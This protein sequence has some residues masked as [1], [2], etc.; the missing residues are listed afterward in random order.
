MKYRFTF[1]YEE[2]L[3]SLRRLPLVNRGIPV[4][5]LVCIALCVAGCPSIWNMDSIDKIQNA[6]ELYKAAE[7]HFQKKEYAKAI[8]AY[9][10]L[11]SAYPDYKEV[12]EA[13]LKIGDALFNDGAYD[14]AIARYSQ[15]LEL[16]PAHKEVPRAKYQIAMA[17]FKQI[18]NIDLDSRI[19]QKSAESFK[20]VMD[21]P[22]GGEWAKKAEEKYRESRQMLADKELYKA[23][24]YI[25][26]GNYTAARSAARRVLDEYS[27]LGRD[28]E[29][30][31][32]IKKIKNK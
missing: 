22:D 19:V 5:I 20:A 2:F 7:D 10:R 29:A 12:P 3:I 4:V 16:Y 23:R 15:F 31:E 24:T 9:E 13:Y 25:S 32:L 17:S 11:K 21:D 28:E 1:K 14:K 30:N 8:E 26:I 18:K 27:K 6:D